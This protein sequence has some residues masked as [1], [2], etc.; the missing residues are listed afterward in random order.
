MVGSKLG[1]DQG[2]H[3]GYN[4]GGYGETASRTALKLA[5]CLVSRH[6]Y[7][8]SPMTSGGKSQPVIGCQQ[9]K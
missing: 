8:H 5:H 1:F 6:N 2:C 7:E 3:D 9:V 4:D